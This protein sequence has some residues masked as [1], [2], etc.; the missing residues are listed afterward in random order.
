MEILVLNL[1]L[2]HDYFDIFQDRLSI[3]FQIVHEK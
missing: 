1:L 3:L 2:I